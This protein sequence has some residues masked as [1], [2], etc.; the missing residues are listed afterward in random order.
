MLTNV[1]SLT[2]D[3]GLAFTQIF[4]YKEQNNRVFLDFT[5]YTFKAQ[6]RTAK[7]PIAQLITTVVPV[8]VGLGQLKLTLTDIQTAKFIGTSAYY[9]I[10][11]STSGGHPEKIFEGSVSLNETVSQ[12]GYTAP[13]TTCSIATAAHITPA[14]TITL[15]SN[16]LGA[17]IKY[18]V[19]DA[20][21]AAD[22][23]VYTTPFTLTAG[24][25][26]LRFFATGDTGTESIKTISSVVVA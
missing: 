22:F 18:T 14:T 17:V 20:A 9:D 26:N 21:L 24:T 10:L 6:F 7:N 13:T 5:A 25:R 4:E 1:Q 19:D 3:K 16:E 15:T 2:I 23:I 12:W 11:A 8:A